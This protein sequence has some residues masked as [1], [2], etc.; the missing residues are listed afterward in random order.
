MQIEVLANDEAVASR[1]AAIIAENARAAVQARGRFLMAVSGGRTPWV[2]LRLLAKEDV[3]WNDVHVLQ[4]DE[5]IAPAGDPDRN[6]THLRETLL[7]HAPIEPSHIYA[8]R[9]EEADSEAAAAQYAK[10]IEKLA[11]VPPVIDLV[12][13]GLGPDGHTASLIPG[14]PV[15][16]VTDRDVAITGVYQGRNRMT[17]T[18]PVINRARQILWVVTGS[19]KAKPLGLLMKADPSIPGGRV[20]QDHAVVVADREAAGQT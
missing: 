20:S 18:Y 6:L 1:A 14:D 5:R 9:V 8:M 12:H 10:T 13:L 11:G 3:P 4:V 2:M 17:L 19:E 7:Q 15:L 16:Q